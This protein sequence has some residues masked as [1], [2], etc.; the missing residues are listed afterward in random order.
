MVELPPR[1]RVPDEVIARDLAGEALIV[2]LGTGTYF[3]LDAT[4]TRMW[5]LL[6]EHNLR[7]Y[8]RLMGDIREAIRADAFVALREH[9][10]QIVMTEET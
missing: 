3:G 8:V 7:F 1:V 6:A 9:R 4:G 5:Q 10:R 2:H